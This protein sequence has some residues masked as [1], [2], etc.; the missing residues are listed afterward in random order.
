MIKI[1]SFKVNCKFRFTVTSLLTPQSPSPSP[2]IIISIIIC[3]KWAVESSDDTVNLLT[4]SQCCCF[5]NAGSTFSRMLSIQ[6]RSGLPFGLSPWTIPSIT[7]FT[8]PSVRCFFASV[9]NEWNQLPHHIYS[10]QLVYSFKASLLSRLIVVESCPL[11]KPF[12]KVVGPSFTLLMML[13]WP[14]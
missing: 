12:N 7:V 14:G 5:M 6:W 11:M 2:I 3:L 9:P 10:A 1:L 13:L 8:K 4:P